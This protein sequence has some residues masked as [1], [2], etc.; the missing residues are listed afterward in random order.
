MACIYFTVS[1]LQLPHETGRDP[2]PLTYDIEVC[3]ARVDKRQGKVA[4]WA[5][6]KSASRDAP[7]HVLSLSEWEQLKLDEALS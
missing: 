3:R 5:K 4:D 7:C 1:K 2:L 6:C